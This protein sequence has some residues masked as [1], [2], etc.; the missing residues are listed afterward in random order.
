VQVV[1]SLAELRTPRQV[2]TFPAGVLAAGIHRHGSGPRT[3]TTRLSS[4]S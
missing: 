4:A 3:S 2:S 1:P